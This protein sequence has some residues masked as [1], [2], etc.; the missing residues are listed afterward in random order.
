MSVAWRLPR[1]VVKPYAP[2]DYCTN[3]TMRRFG[4]VLR[5]HHVSCILGTSYYPSL[6]CLK[7]LIPLM[8]LPFYFHTHKDLRTLK[9]QSSHIMRLHLISI[10]FYIIKRTGGI[11]PSPKIN[12]I[13]AILIEVKC[14]FIN[15]IDYD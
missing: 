13:K 4:K 8:L 2:I 7:T 11:S 15:F 1:C 3:V 6:S 10:P 14:R 12:Y 5:S 9:M